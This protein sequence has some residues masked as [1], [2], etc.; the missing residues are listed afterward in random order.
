MPADKTVE[1]ASQLV[2]VVFGWLQDNIVGAG[3]F[4]R[5]A[6]KGLFEPSEAFP[7]VTIRCTFW[8]DTPEIEIF[9]SLFFGIEKRSSEE[10]YGGGEFFVID[11]GGRLHIITSVLV[12]EKETSGKNL[13]VLRS[14][15]FPFL[16][17]W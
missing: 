7:G 17:C 16:P 9:N 2:E 15:F 14:V 13:T 5:C 1:L 8:S 10:C 12:V 3:V 6:A 4:Y 11:I